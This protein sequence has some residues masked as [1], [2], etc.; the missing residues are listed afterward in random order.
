M[1]S[2]TLRVSMNW[3]TQL[4]WKHCLE[5]SDSNQRNI[6]QKTA[7]TLCFQNNSTRLK[8]HFV[9]IIGFILSKFSCKFVVRLFQFRFL[10]RLMLRCFISLP[11]VCEFKK[12]S[13]VAVCMCMTRDFALNICK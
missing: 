10:K 4:S 12:S 9:V 2:L 8:I 3:T 1:V 5:K 6:S 7:E 13:H 11:V